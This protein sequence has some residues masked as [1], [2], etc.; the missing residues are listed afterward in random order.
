LVFVE[1]DPPFPSDSIQKLKLVP[2][3]LCISSRKTVEFCGCTGICDKNG[4][5]RPVM[6]QPPFSL[7]KP[8]LAE[9]LLP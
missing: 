9:D 8:E 4:W 1:K 7:L 6:H 5:P 3:F 2:V